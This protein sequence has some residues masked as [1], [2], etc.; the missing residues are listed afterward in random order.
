MKLATLIAAVMLLQTGERQSP[1]EPSGGAIEGVVV[2]IGTGEP[3]AQTQVR[4]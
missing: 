1:H 4:V 3:I 2:R